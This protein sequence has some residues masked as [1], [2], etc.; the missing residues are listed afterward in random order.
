MTQYTRIAF[1]CYKNFQKIKLG[2]PENRGDSDQWG[3]CVYSPSREG[4]VELLKT[5]SSY[6]YVNKSVKT[7]EKN[8]WEKRSFLIKECQQSN[9][10]I[11]LTEINTCKNKHKLNSKRMSY[12]QL[13][14]WETACLTP[15]APS[16][17]TLYSTRD[18]V[19]LS[20]SLQSFQWS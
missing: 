5:L 18:A 4:R 1:S 16:F 11:S 20:T 7:S 10:K 6:W 12:V 13:M 3:S 19:T 2:I 15:H 8:I 9:T 17:V 14:K